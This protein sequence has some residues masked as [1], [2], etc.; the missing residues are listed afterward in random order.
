MSSHFLSVPPFI[1]CVY[2]S[3]NIWNVYFKNVITLSRVGLTFIYRRRNFPQR[4]SRLIKM[5]KSKYSSAIICLTIHLLILSG[6]RL[7][8]NINHSQDLAI[9]RFLKTLHSSKWVHL[10]FFTLGLGVFQNKGGILVVAPTRIISPV[11]FQLW[12]GPIGTWTG[13]GLVVFWKF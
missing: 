8:M 11:Q 1:H 5:Q 2:I 6:F 9:Y 7:K 4:C 13:L 12:I 3:M 10:V